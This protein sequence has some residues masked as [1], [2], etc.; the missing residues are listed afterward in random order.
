MDL[1]YQSFS[2]IKV[3]YVEEPQYIKGS[4]LK[5]LFLLIYLFTFMNFKNIIDN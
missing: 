4:V 3:S 1:L 5:F 2:D